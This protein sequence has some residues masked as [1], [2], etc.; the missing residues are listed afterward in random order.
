M[1]IHGTPAEPEYVVPDH[2]RFAF[3]EAVGLASSASAESGTS[4]ILNVN[5]PLIST[6]GLS[7]RDVQEAGEYLWQTIEFEAKRRG[8]RL[9][10]A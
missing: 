7:K 6:S 1:M 3:A 4:I 5:S 9:S 10:N 2:D 8:M